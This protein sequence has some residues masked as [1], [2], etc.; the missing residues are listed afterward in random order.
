MILAIK[1]IKKKKLKKSTNLK[2]KMK[3]RSNK[4]LRCNSRRQPQQKKLRPSKSSSSNLTK[5]N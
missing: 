4:W 3:R 5:T 2:L 1:K